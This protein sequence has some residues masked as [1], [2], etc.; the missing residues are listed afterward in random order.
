VIW[1]I[2]V[3]AIPVVISPIYRLPWRSPVQSFPFHI[4]HGM[5]ARELPFAVIQRG[6]WLPPR[7]GK[8]ILS[9]KEENSL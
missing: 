7:S 3:C 5:G 2:K 9:Y 6:A 1:L 4:A 8:C